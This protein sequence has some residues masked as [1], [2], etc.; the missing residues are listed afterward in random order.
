MNVRMWIHKATQKNVKY[1]KI[2]D[3]YLLAL[4]KVK[5]LVGNMVK[6]KC[7]VQDKIYSYIENYFNKKDL[8]KN[9]N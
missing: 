5:W 6:E 2:M 3:I 4:K 9:K 7:Q 1:L 8:V